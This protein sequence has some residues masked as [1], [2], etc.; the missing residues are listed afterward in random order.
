MITS[1][2]PYAPCSHC[3]LEVLTGI[4]DQGVTLVLDPHQRCY[5]VLWQNNAPQPDLRPSG[6]Y[7]VHRCDAGAS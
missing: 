1:S 7:P 5:V 4:T 3:G 2:P 6:A